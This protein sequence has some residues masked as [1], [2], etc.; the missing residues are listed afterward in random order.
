M[1]DD[2]IKITDALLSWYFWKPII[3]IVT[4]VSSIVSIYLFIPLHIILWTLGAIF[5]ICLLFG[6]GLYYYYQHIQ[7]LENNM[8]RLTGRDS[9][10]K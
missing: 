3:L 7:N 2:E 5:A 8:N 4:L 9:W 6:V 1:S 10:N